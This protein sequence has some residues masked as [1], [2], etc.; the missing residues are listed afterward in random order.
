MTKNIL[1]KYL[2]FLEDCECLRIATPAKTRLNVKKEIMKL[3]PENFRISM[4]P[5]FFNHNDAERIGTV[6][7]DSS[8]NFLID[9]PK[10]VKFSTKHDIT[11]RNE[12]ILF[13][14]FAFLFFFLY[15]SP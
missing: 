9:T 4:M 14:P 15:L 11:V 5:I 13:V 3:V 2:D 12:I 6:I 1:K 7:K 8:R 10:K